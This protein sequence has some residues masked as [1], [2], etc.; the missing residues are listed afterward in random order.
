M[1]GQLFPHPADERP[2]SLP[3]YVKDLQVKRA[4][5]GESNRTVAQLSGYD[6]FKTNYNS[7]NDEPYREAQ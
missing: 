5:W 1:V 3:H 7:L 6:V 4:C 2:R